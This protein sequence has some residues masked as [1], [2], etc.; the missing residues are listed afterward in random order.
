MRR[1]ASGPAAEDIDALLDEL[2]ETVE[3][4][5]PS[6][7]SAQDRR[8]LT[9][10]E[11]IL[12]FVDAT[13]RPPGHGDERDLFERRYAVRLDRLR[14]DPQCRAVLSDVDRHGLL[15]A[16]AE[17]NIDDEA[18]LLAE[19]GLDDA[20]EA[21]DDITRLRHVRPRAEVRDDI[22]VREPCAEFDRFRERFE[23]VRLDLASGDR[24]LLPI[25][26]EMPVTAIEVGGF[27]VVHGMTAYIAD[28]EAEFR[29]ESGNRDRRLRVIYDNATESDLLARSL[30]RAL[31]QDPAGRLISDPEAGP[32]FGGSASE[33]DVQSGTIYVLRSLSTHPEI[34]PRREVLHKIG[35]TGGQ[36]ARRIRDARNQ[37]TYLLADVEVVAE[38]RLHNIDRQRL[39]TLLHRFFGAARVELAITD[40]FGNPVR[41][42]EWFL[43]ALPVVEEAIRRLRDGTLVD[44]RYDPQTASL[45]PH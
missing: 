5:P 17:P 6:S 12:S 7:R 22:A 34:E 14:S 21:D 3:A 16:G 19:L 36:V 33:E 39:E 27:F 41:P 29:N 18:Q 2:G 43:V 24:R 13:G 8:V 15:G 11:E 23:A 37:P 31:T 26:A 38:Y 28:A 4:R 25:A 9:G 45:I 20:G 35:V 1:S 44:V 40:R 42:K 10:F 30:Q 32:L